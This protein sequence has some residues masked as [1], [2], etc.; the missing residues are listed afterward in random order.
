MKYGVFLPSARNGFMLSEAAP[1][2]DPT[3][4]HNLDTTLEAEKQGFDFALS[5]MKWK[6]FGGSTGYW[7]SCLETFTLVA[8]MAA[9][10]SSITLIP[11]T[12]LLTTHPAVC[13][14][15]IATIDDVAPGRVGLNVVTG[16]NHLEYES[17][18]LWR[19]ADYYEQRYDFAAEYIEIVKRLWLEDDVHHAGPFFELNGATV[20][21]K[22]SRMPTIVSAGQSPKGLDFT[23]NHAD[24]SFVMTGLENLRKFTSAMNAKSAEI[25][26]SVGTLPLYA[27]I[28][29]RSDAEAQR[30]AEDVVARADRTAIGNILGSASLDTNEGGS[31]AHLQAALSLPVEQGNMAFMSFPLLH[32]TPETVASK[33]NDIVAETGVPGIMLSWLDFVSGIREFGEKVAPKIRY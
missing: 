26:R 9:R 14:R 28:T 10:T 23:V 15:M 20:N 12:T 16:W 13:A 18:G 30:I 11:S 17:M 4:Q 1:L 29:A 24:F 5:M 31:S 2:Y 3:F 7:D 25:G 21:P 6:G 33:I 8:A 19:G 27:V 32:G 22:P